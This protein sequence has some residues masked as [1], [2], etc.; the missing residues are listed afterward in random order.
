[1]AARREGTGI[2]TSDKPNSSPPTGRAAS[3]RSH[4][5]TLPASARENIPSLEDGLK[6]L[7]RLTL[8]GSIYL[9][10]SETGEKSRIDRL[11]N[12]INKVNQSIQSIIASSPTKE[13]EEKLVSTPIAKSGTLNS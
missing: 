11:K 8:R 4:E 6:I 7:P 12:A 2:M 9:S 1:M 10:M 13:T 3:L 5:D